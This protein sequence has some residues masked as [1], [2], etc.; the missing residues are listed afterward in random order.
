MAGRNVAFVNTI[1]GRCALSV[2]DAGMPTPKGWAWAPLSDLAR[3]ESG[4]TPSRNHPE[5][6][7]G[8]IAWVGIKD[9]REHHAR[10]I[11]DTSQHVTQAGIDNSAARVLPANTVCLSRTASVGYV[12]VMGRPMATSQ[13]FVNWVCSPSL[14]PHY[15][16][17]IF[18]AEGEEGLR[19]FGKGTTHTT[20]YF[21][22]VEAFHVA[23]APL[24]EQR[25]IVAKLEAIFDQT[26]AAKGRLERLPALLE[27][28]KR[29]ILAAA[30]RGDLT[31]DWRAAHPE[32]DGLRLHAAIARGVDL[33]IGARRGRKQ[34]P[35]D[36]AA[37]DIQLPPLPSSW[38]YCSVRALYDRNLLVDFA[39]GNHGSNYPRSTE[40][41]AEGVPFVTALQITD[42]GR[43]LLE[44]APRLGHEKAA[45][46]LK[47]WAQ[48]GDVLLTHNATVGRVALVA[49]TIGRFLLGTSATFY[50]PHPEWIDADFLA[51][52]FR[53]PTW[54]R[55]LARVMR[56]TTRDQVSIQRQEPLQVAVAPIEEQQA[57]ALRLTA[58]FRGI[59]SIRQRVQHVSKQASD[60]ETLALAKAF[61]GELAPQDPTD[62]PA[63]FL[64]DRI[65]AARASE[66]ERPRHGRSRRRDDADVAV[67]S[68]DNNGHGA[69]H[70]ES[71]DLVMG[72]FQVDQRLT[73]TAIAKATGLGTPAVKKALKLLVDAGQV[74]ATGTTY[75]WCA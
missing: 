63:S 28:L 27:R 43:V 25:R 20:I 52:Y 4:H 68:A 6:W 24:N 71:L 30:F 70:D 34:A 1:A 2:N 14:L 72:M 19:K 37:A 36:M 13:D 39:D 31:A 50:R 15:L 21:P 33:P 5:Y 73:A 65:R 42:D 3:L 40:F 56:Q 9:A 66:P 47:G 17:W 45:V 74:R 23:V 10:V 53:S 22:E 29:S 7:G 67:A 64:L 75:E 44:D 49:P 46:L 41:G 62:E 51:G 58:W 57:I 61:R 18:L 38:S 35:S 54:Q 59:D 16:K 55:Q 69:D 26:R 32:I 11:D 12:V 60:I 48:G 8:D